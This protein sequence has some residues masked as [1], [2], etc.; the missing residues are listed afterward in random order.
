MDVLKIIKTYFKE[1]GL[2]KPKAVFLDDITPMHGRIYAVKCGWFKI[3]TYHVYI[4]GGKIYSVRL[5]G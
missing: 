5:R 3:R 4:L 1:H 2:P